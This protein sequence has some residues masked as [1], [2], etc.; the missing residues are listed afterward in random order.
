MAAVLHRTTLQYL[1]SANTPDYPVID[2]IINPDLSAVIG[3]ANKYWKVTG[4]VVSEMTQGEKD[5]KDAADLTFQRDA[6][7]AQLQ[8][9]EDVLRAFMLTVLDEL[10]LHAAKTNS[11]MTAI[12]NNST[13]ANIK[14]AIAAIADYPTRT[15]TQLRTTIRSKLGS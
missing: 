9:T 12:D 3:V 2:W 10:N 15:E 11:I 13:L 5:A 1:P 8:Q 14:T 4:D 6:A 7:V